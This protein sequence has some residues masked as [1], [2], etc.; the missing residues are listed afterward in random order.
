MD[1]GGYGGVGEALTCGQLGMGAVVFP[2][3]A[4]SGRPCYPTPPYHTTPTP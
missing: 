1:V 4:T 3:G 2:V